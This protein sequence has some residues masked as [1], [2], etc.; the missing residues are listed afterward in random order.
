MREQ[1]VS[2]VRHPLLDFGA[3]LG[4]DGSAY[5]ATESRSPVIFLNAGR[6]SLLAQAQHEGR[7][8]V[9]MTDELSCLTPA[10]AE[11]WRE[12]G[13]AWVVRSPNGL[14][15]G[16]TGRRL[17]EIGDVF[18]ASAIRSID[19][20]DL[21]FLRPGP[22]TAV[23]L[24]AIISLRHQARPTTILGGPIEGIAKI[25]SGDPPRVWG[26]HEPAGN[27]WRREDLTTFAQSQMPGPVL[28]VAIG[29]SF[30]STLTVQRTSAGIEEITEA[31]LSLGVPSTVAF[32]DHRTRM[33]G[34]LADLAQNAMPLVGLIMA[35][36]GREDLL[37]PAFLQHAPTPMALLIGPPAVRAL[38][39]SVDQMVRQF[40][41]LRVGRP[42]IPG[43]LFSL[44]SL[45]EV[46]WP[47]L[48]EILTALGG[49]QVNEILGL[50]SRHTSQV[51]AH[52]E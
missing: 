39:V 40:G 27:L 24:M 25:T 26:A 4:A 8:A 30:R 20:I 42:R 3:A 47:L 50:S 37:I 7:R 28:V 51:A 22:A 48:D 10:F 9:L 2:A 52:A 44:G 49:D 14:R 16:F 18:A 5:A 15:E 21:G 46:T 29:R 17:S 13:A 43:L 12:A 6:V 36:P 41:A 34:Y 33:I 11:V 31:H 19:D 38:D 45:G 23:Q 35:R 32:E 1:S